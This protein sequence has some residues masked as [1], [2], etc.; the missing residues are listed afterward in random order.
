MLHEERGH[1]AHMNA[2]GELCAQFRKG[3]LAVMR[4]AGP[5]GVLETVEAYHALHP[6]AAGQAWHPDALA[7]LETAEAR[8]LYVNA[9]H[10]GDVGV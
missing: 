10:D 3:I 2:I 9:E 5:D 1:L 7:A 8:Q 6:A 4:E